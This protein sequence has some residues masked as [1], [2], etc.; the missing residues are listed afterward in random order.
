M[1]LVVFRLT[2]HRVTM[3]DSRMAECGGMT[4]WTSRVK[5]RGLMQDRA[6]SR[7][8]LVVLLSVSTES[9]MLIAAGVRHSG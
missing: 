1:T 5:W 3:L 9:I 2:G 7:L 8:G 4:V 6:N